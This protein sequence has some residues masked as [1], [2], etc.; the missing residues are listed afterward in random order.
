MACWEGGWR[1]EGAVGGTELGGFNGQW[2]EARG[3]GDVRERWMSGLCFLWGSRLWPC[4]P[5]L[6]RC[7]SGAGLVQRGFEDMGWSWSDEPL[8][9][10]FGELII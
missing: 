8:L 9:V 4:I 7:F 10:R 6:W 1:G 3:R 5:S 2:S